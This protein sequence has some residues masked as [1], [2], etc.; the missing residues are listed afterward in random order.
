[1][2]CILLNIAFLGACKTPSTEGLP[3][4]KDPYTKPVAALYIY[5]TDLFAQ[6]FTAICGEKTFNYHIDRETERT[7]FLGIT[8]QEPCVLT[9]GNSKHE[10]VY[11][12]EEYNCSFSD[13]TMSCTKR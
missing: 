6:S 10:P 5:H 7:V 9:Y 3:K 11:G 4:P 2:I 13:T 1:M 8:T 12:G